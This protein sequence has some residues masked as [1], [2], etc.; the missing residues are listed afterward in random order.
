M[1]LLMIFYRTALISKEDLATTRRAHKAVNDTRK[2][3]PQDYSK[4]YHDW[5]VK[6]NTQDENW[7]TNH[8]TNIPSAASMWCVC[9]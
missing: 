7:T 2:S 4:R 3:V 5:I 1:N 9:V 6:I 8:I